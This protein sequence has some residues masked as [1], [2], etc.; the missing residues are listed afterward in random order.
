MKHILKEVGK[1]MDYDVKE[2]KPT[3][4][5]RRFDMIW[6]KTDDRSNRI[7]IEHEND[8]SDI[9]KEE[10]H[11]LE[12][13]RANLQVCITYVSKP[14]ECPGEEYAKKLEKFLLNREFNEFIL[15]IGS[16]DF[17][18]SSEWFFYRFYRDVKFDRI[19]FPSKITQIPLNKE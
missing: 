9:F 6:E 19:V 10:I 7:I 14:E 5:G 13:A 2:E 1:R 11:K 16:Y 8:I 4:G 15:V 17:N 18:A 3:I 12:L